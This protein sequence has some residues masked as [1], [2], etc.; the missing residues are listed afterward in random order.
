MKHRIL[1][2]VVCILYGS[3]T[4]ESLPGVLRAGEFCPLSGVQRVV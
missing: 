4:I 3:A 2:R 1:A